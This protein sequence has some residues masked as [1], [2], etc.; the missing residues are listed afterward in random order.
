MYVWVTSIEWRVESTREGQF[1]SCLRRQAHSADF[2]STTR[3][4]KIPTSESTRGLRDA[5]VGAFLTQI[6][7]KHNPGSRCR[8]HTGFNG[9]AV[10]ASSQTMAG[11]Y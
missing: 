3:V 2:A 9:R 5:V 8:S 4:L 6:Q 7:G 10:L 11:E 1:E